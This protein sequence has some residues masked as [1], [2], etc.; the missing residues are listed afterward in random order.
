MCKI[1]CPTNTFAF[2][3]HKTAVLW[4]FIICPSIHHYYNSIHWEKKNRKLLFLH[5]TVYPHIQY[6]LCSV[7]CV[8]SAAIY[9]YLCIIIFICYHVI[10]MYFIK[11]FVYFIYNMWMTF[12]LLWTLLYHLYFRVEWISPSTFELI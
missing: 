10:P 3:S 2:T 8:S 5:F 12:K 6:I 4:A 1:K 7:Y 11:Y 9:W